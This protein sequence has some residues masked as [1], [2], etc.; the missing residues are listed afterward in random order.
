MS[1]TTTSQ[2][3]EPMDEPPYKP[4]CRIQTTV[5]LVR[6]GTVLAYH[7]PTDPR[8]PGWLDVRWDDAPR[9]SCAGVCER[10]VAPSSAVDALAGLL[11]RPEA[12]PLATTGLVYL[13]DDGSLG[14][15]YLPGSDMTRASAL[16]LG[17]SMLDDEGKPE[18]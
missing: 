10:H 13:M 8:D 7:P 3:D 15:T 4:G 14:G 17:F 5:G 2:F 1:A 9:E 11:R 12:I 18:W 6:V 16:A